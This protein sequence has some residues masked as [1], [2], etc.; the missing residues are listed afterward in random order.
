ME[1][2]QSL[3]YRRIPGGAVTKARELRAQGLLYREIGAALGV[4]MATAHR[5]VNRKEHPRR[6]VSQCCYCGICLD[7]VRTIHDTNVGQW[8]EGQCCDMCYHHVNGIRRTPQG[9]MFWSDKELARGALQL[10]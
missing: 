1:K 10:T 9:R 7:L 2:E 6:D 4:S 5:Y 3:A 8:N